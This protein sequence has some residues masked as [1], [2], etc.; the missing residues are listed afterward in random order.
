MGKRYWDSGIKLVQM[1]SPSRE[2]GRWS[3]SHTEITGDLRE[4]RKLIHRKQ[5][6]Q[7]EKPEMRDQ[8]KKT[9]SERESEFV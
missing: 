6:K 2:N 7:T 3:C 1:Q 5:N 4:H 8:R 9:E